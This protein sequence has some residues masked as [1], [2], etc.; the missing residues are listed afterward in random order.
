MHQFCSRQGFT[1]IRG[2]PLVVTAGQSF[3]CHIDESN[4][5][6]EGGLTKLTVL[7]YLSGGN[8]DKGTSKGKESSATRLI[9]GGETIFYN[10]STAKIGGKKKS[11][12]TEAARVPPQCGTLLIHSH[13]DRCLTHEASPVVEG[14]KYVLRTDVVYIPSR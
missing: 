14:V 2:H 8:K 7:V 5:E 10:E 6:P 13:G 3:G 4:P 9:V 1:K 11:I 12:R